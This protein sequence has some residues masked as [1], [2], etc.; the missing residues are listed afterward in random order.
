VAVAL[1]ALP[2]SL[3]PLAAAPAALGPAIA[4][5]TPGTEALCFVTT[6]SLTALAL[7]ALVTRAKTDLTLGGLTHKKGYQGTLSCRLSCV[8]SV[9]TDGL[10]HHRPLEHGL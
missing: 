4:V 1:L 2:L 3:L 7:A 5:G 9:E 6:D 8:L 10:L